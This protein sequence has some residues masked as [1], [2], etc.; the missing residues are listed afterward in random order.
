MNKVR[1]VIEF[2]STAIRTFES[3]IRVR[4]SRLGRGF[5]ENFREKRAEQ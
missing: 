1:E 4:G 3:T 2:L 5:Y